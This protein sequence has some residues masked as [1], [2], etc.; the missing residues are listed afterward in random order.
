MATRRRYP[1]L[2]PCILAFF[3]SL[4]LSLATKTPKNRS[5]GTGFGAKT[6]WKIHDTDDSAEIQRLAQFLQKQKADIQNVDVGFDPNTQ[7]RGLFATKNFKKGQI[8]CKIPSDC[9]LALSDPA[10]KGEDAPTVAHGGANLLRMYIQDPQQRDI[11]AFYLDTL[12]Q[13]PG[14]DATPDFMDSS[15]IDLLEF[16]R[17]VERAKERKQQIQ[18]LATA[19]N[20]PVDDLQYATWIVSSRAFPISL[21]SDDI[22]A[23]TFDERGQVIAK[24]DRKW[25]RVLVPYIDLANHNSDPNAKLTLI[26]PQKDDA[27]FALEALRP[28]SQ[29]KEIC[30]AYGS[31]VDS[32][33]ELF[34]NYGFVPTENKID[35]LMLKKGGDDAIASIDGWS[36]TLEEDRAMLEMTSE[37]DVN[38]R[39]ILSFRIKLKESYQEEE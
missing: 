4:I 37:D 33:A 8:I 9:A 35:A 26:D 6:S 12:P 11:W 31:G 38:L 28:I 15:E 24:A 3:P 5:S 13:S 1:A 14:S 32:T 22:T 23:A 39:K 20:I 34:L 27:W 7:R 2:I 17:V 18:E 25:I 29:G 10:K 30:I 36:T 16:P 21:S 19:N